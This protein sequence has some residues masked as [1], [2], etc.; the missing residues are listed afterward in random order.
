M[1][2]RM[3]AFLLCEHD[4]VATMRARL[5][6]Y[7]ASTIVL[8][9]CE[10]DCVATMRARLCSYCESMIALLLYEHDCVATVRARLRCYYAS[11]IVLLLCEHDCVA[12]VL[13]L[14]SIHD[15]WALPKWKSSSTLPALQDKVSLLSAN[16]IGAT[17]PSMALT[18]WGRHH[19]RH[20]QLAPSS[21]SAAGTIIDVSS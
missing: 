14:S 9:L 4:C 15:G 18:E 13:A 1:V 5:C 20:Q 10:H 21:T 2:A 11:T 7:Y 3:I 17:S 6:C 16:I 8:L 19:H 12:I